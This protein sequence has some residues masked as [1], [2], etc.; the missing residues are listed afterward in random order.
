M[1][2]PQLAFLIWTTAVIVAGG[3]KFRMTECLRWPG[4]MGILLV[5]GYAGSIYALIGARV[6]PF[7][8]PNVAFV[9]EIA[10]NPEVDDELASA[11]TWANTHVARDAILQ[12]D[13]V[14]DKRVVD[15]GLYGR[16][17][18]AVADSEAVLYGAARA[19]VS[20]RLAAIGPIFTRRLSAAEVRSRAFDYG[21]DV[22]VVSSADPVWS[23][24]RDWVWST[25]VLF[26]SPRVRL[27]ATRD[28]D[29]GG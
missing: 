10:L 1:L 24:R 12:H 28:L 2:L 20:A 22:L 9:P 3:E 27:I 16:N 18:V 21:I 15:F 8:A 14:S 4:A 29:P 19:D 26:A 23:D 7:L 13:P 5:I 17:R 25:P 11:Y 6:Y